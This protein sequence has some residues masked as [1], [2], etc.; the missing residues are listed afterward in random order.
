MVRLQA[1]IDY[2]ILHSSLF[3]LQYSIFT[4][5]SSMT[6]SISHTVATIVTALLLWLSP[7]GTITAQTFTDHLRQNSNGKATVSVTQ[8]A[9]IE[10]LVNSRPAQTESQKLA[11][12]KAQ[13]KTEDKAAAAKPRNDSQ[14]SSPAHE[15]TRHDDDNDGGNEMN[16]PTVD[17]RKKVMKNSYKTIGY[18]VQ[19]FAGR[20]SK[21][22]RLKA[23][24]IGNAIKM[25][26]PDQPVYV[27]FYSPR[28][29]CRIGNYRTY[30]E[31][32]QM[33]KLVKEMGY[34]AATIVKGQ[35]TVQ[36]K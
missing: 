27:H 6:Q 34:T 13:Q 10:Q 16:I 11:A 26:Y 5:H 23:E 1:P 33:L 15:T 25:K 30:E 22:D 3:T 4:H 9:E 12:Q 36:D 29:I 35:I 20:N 8:S 14:N 19:A 18:R 2:W 32:N 7:F 28:W 17:M 31:A 24:S 21:A